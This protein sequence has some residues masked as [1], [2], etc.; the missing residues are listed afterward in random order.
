[1]KLTIY[2]F[3]FLKE[4]TVFCCIDTLIFIIKHQ[5]APFLDLKH[6][7]LMGSHK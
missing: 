1:M 6:T 7:N 4:L 5:E 3:S 2:C